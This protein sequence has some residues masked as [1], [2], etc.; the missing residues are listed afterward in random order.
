MLST[1]TPEGVQTVKNNPQRIREV[2][3][4][5]EQLGATRQGAVGDARPLR[6]RQRRRGA[7]REDD[8]ARL[9][10]AGLARH[11][12]LRDAD[13]DPDRR[14]HRARSERPAACGSSSSASGGR[15]HALVRALARSPQAPELLCAP[16]NAGHRRRRRLL[17]RRRGR[18][19]RRSSRAAASGR[20]PRRGRARGAAG[21]RPRRRAGRG[22]HRRASARAPRP[23]GW[24]APRRSPRR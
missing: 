23:R 18:R 1:L 16:G 4:E 2:N 17:R 14:L 15:E 7:R 6:L 21:R 8:R 11:R 22:R 10:G 19:R 13:R 12:Q 3:R 20:R 24:R 9:A 5:V